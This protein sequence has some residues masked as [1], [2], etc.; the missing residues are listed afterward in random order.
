MHRHLALPLLC[1]LGFLPDRL[2]AGAWPREQG[3]VFLS[4]GVSLAWPQDMSHWTSTAPTQD[5]RTIYMEYGLTNRLTL[6]FDLGRSVSGENKTIG[7]VQFPM[8]DK[9]TGAK[10][11]LQLGLG[12]I[13]DRPILRPGMAVGWP[14]DRGWFSADGV[15]EISLKDGATDLK[16]DV[17]WGRNLARDRK[18]ILQMQFGAPKN[19]PSFARFAPS[20]VVPLRKGLK[21]EI[22]ATWGISGDSSMGLKFGLWAEF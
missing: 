21:S 20:V 14:L 2:D 8:R 3:K 17:T 19:D 1:L 10:I 4:A 12:Q 18:L 6:G 7:F 13:G 5:Y 15:A 9:T 22:G 16:L 11:A